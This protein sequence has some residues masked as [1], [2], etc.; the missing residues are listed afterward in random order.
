M[1]PTTV[2]NTLRTAWISRMKKS[3]TIQKLYDRDGNICG[4]HTGGC[5]KEVLRNDASVDHIIPKMLIHKLGR[6]QQDILFEADFN[7]QI[8]H[9][10][11]NNS[12]QTHGDDLPTFNCVCHAKARYTTGHLEFW[13]NLQ[14]SNKHQKQMYHT[15]IILI[16]SITDMELHTIY[17]PNWYGMNITP[18]NFS[19]DDHKIEDS[20]RKSYRVVSAS[21]LLTIRRGKR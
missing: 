13:T 19:P 21:Y 16:R 6:R 4:P 12:R 8:M 14:T 20:D 1:K 15:L 3:E 18:G 11:C 2:P 9:E 7:K 17:L 10:K 5:G